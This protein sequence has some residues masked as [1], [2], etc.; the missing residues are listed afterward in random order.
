M[1]TSVIEVH[2]LLSVLSVDEVETRIGEVPGVD[3]VTVN[4]AAASATVRYDETRIVAAEIRS[5]VRQRGYEPS[6]PSGASDGDEH[7]DHPASPATPGAT[8]IKTAPTAP[9]EASEI[10]PPAGA[11]K[12]EKADQSEP[13]MK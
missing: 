6:A 12:T 9:P 4:F 2:D 8:A 1:K 5:V 7:K 13:E 3:S 11:A 10:V